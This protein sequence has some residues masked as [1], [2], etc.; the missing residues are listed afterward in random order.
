MQTIH[1]NR[2]LPHRRTPS[3]RVVLHKGSIVRVRRHGDS[4]RLPRLLPNAQR[5]MQFVLYLG[6][7]QQVLKNG[8]GHEVQVQAEGVSTGVPSLL[9]DLLSVGDDHPVVGTQR[10]CNARP[11]GL[12]EDPVI[13][14][15][16][17]TLVVHIELR[18]GN[19][20]AQDNLFPFIVFDWYFGRLVAA[21]PND[22]VS[23]L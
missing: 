18:E 6:L 3:L 22:D 10:V 4:G 14:G 8:V 12:S 16:D 11:E 20:L 2:P 19:L 7:G 21:S 13:H 5:L 15:Q 23:I 9:L 1:C 17:A